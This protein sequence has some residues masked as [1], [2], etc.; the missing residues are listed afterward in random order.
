MMLLNKNDFVFLVLS[1]LTLAS[2]PLHADIT[3]N[4]IA[5]Y[6]FE[7]DFTDSKGSADG[8]PIG[9]VSF[10]AGKV[11]QQAA[12][13]N[14]VDGWIDIG[15]LPHGDLS[16]YTFSA[17]V[18]V[19][20]SLDNKAMMSNYP[21][22]SNIHNIINFTIVRDNHTV[23]PSNTWGVHRDADPFN[24]GNYEAG[25]SV[26]STST[27][28]DQFTHI[29]IVR[30]VAASEM[31]IYING[32]LD[33]VGVLTPLTQLPMTRNTDWK[34]GRINENYG[35]YFY[36]ALDDVRLY[37]RAL[38]DD[39]IIQ[40]SNQGNKIFS[41]GFETGDTS[42][43]D[44][45]SAQI[46]KMSATNVT[47]YQG[48]YSARSTADYQIL[49]KQF[50]AINSGIAIV[51]AYVMMTQ[52][53]ANSYLAVVI[54][55]DLYGGS[56][57]HIGLAFGRPE[58][59]FVSWFRDDNWNED[60]INHPQTAQ[61]G[62]WYKVTLKH[63]FNTG[64]SSVY[65]NDDFIHQKTT[66]I[67]SLSAIWIGDGTQ[68]SGGDVISDNYF[69]D[70]ITV[71]HSSSIDTV[72]ST[73][74]IIPSTNPTPIDATNSSTEGTNSCNPTTTITG[75]PGPIVA[76]S[77]NYTHTH[78]DFAIPGLGPRL[79]ITRYYNSQDLYDGPFS[80][81]WNIDYTAQLLL[82]EDDQGAQTATVRLGNGVRR[83]FTE[84]VDGSWIPPE[85]QDDTLLTQGTG[86]SAVYVFNGDCGT[87][88]VPKPR[89]SYSFNADG[90]LQI[91]TD[92]NGNTLT[93]GYDGSGRISAV[94]NP[95][96][97]SLSFAYGT[98]GRVSTVTDHD[99]RTWTYGYDPLTDDLISVEDPLGNT[100]QYAYDDAHNLISL[101]D[102]KGQVQQ[103]MT[104]LTDDKVAYFSDQ[105]GAYNV[106][107][108]SRLLR[109][110][111]TNPEGGL[112][113]FNYDN[114]GNITNKTNALGHQSALTWDANVDLTG[115][116]NGRNVETSYSY[117]AQHNVTQVIRDAGN[118]NLTS[119][120]SYDPVTGQVA[121][122]INPR[123]I[124]TQMLYDVN[125]NLDTV[126]RDALGSPVV[127]DTQYN[128]Q[129]Q[130]TQSTDADGI[131][132]AY[133]YDADGYMTRVYNPNVLP[134]DPQIET[135]YTYDARGNRLTQTDANGNTTTY[136]YDDLDRV[137][138]VTDALTN[139]T[140]FVY[141][142]NGN[143]TQITDARNN[144]TQLAYDSYDRLISRT[145]A[146]GTALQR[147]T[148]YT[149]DSRGNLL[150]VTDPLLHTT[151]YTYDLIS[152][153]TQACDHLNQCWSF[154]YDEAGNL[155]SKTDPNNHS[156][157]YGYD[158]IDRLAS[159]NDAATGV[160]QY[161]YDANS[162]LTQVTD[163]NIHT[164]AQ[165]TYDNLDRLTDTQDAL[166]FNTQSSYSGAG[167]I[168]TITDANS[169]LITNGYDGITGRLSQT[170][171]SAGGTDSYT[172]DPVGN[173]LSV[174]DSATGITLGYTYDALNRIATETQQGKTLTYTYDENGNRTGLNVTGIGS[175]SYTYD[176]L[177]RLISIQNPDL[178]TTAFEYNAA[179]LRT[180]VTY[181]NGSTTEYTYDAVNRLTQILHKKAD[182]TVISG[183][184][185]TYD[186]MN[187]RL[188]E[189]DANSNTL[190]TYVYDERYQL[191]SATYADTNETISFTY[192]AV[193]NRLT[194]TDGSGTTSYTYNDANQ[195]TDQN[196]PDGSL[197]TY[198]YLPN[199]TPFT[200]IQ[201]NP[202][203][204]TFTTTYTYDSKDRL[205]QL[206]GSD[207]SQ[208][209]FEYDPAGRRIST[210]VGATL[211]KHLYDGQNPLAELDDL[212]AIQ[213]T[214]TPALTLDVLASRKTGSTTEYYLR[215]GLNSVRTIV[216]GTE[217]ETASYLYQPYGKIRTKTG[218]SD[219]AFTFTGRRIV[220]NT[221][222]MFYRS[223]YYD[224]ATGRF[225][226]KD[227]YKGKLNDPL[228]MHRYIYVQNNPVNYVDPLGF[229]WV[230]P[231]CFIIPG[232]KYCSSG[233][234]DTDAIAEV[235]YQGDGIGNS[236]STF[237]M[238]EFEYGETIS[239]DQTDS[240]ISIGANVD[241]GVT[242]LG[243]IDDE[244]LED[245]NE[246]VS[247][248]ISGNYKIG[249]ELSFY[250]NKQESFLE[251][252]KVWDSVAG[253]NAGISGGIGGE[254]QVI[255]MTV[256]NKN[257]CE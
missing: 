88:C 157:G 124:S 140:S 2:F 64:V 22:G 173:L 33:T 198:H 225:L 221:D 190:V 233:G 19:R 119:S 206:N 147:S 126:T 73:D 244:A 235:S 102:A 105:G 27:I 152:Q 248:D 14:G 4:L 32:N 222:L 108:N 31:R 132:T 35:R 183:H 53:E 123:S 61:I 98:N 216:D 151:T 71:Y 254:F 241:A 1:V 79:G 208:Q 142:A 38:S 201:T 138:S 72:V 50:A 36:G 197:T 176:A 82:S 67:N 237:T 255:E 230:S 212:N 251:Y 87:G 213:T 45:Y 165:N 149:Y 220:D 44:Q 80:H 189:T 207:G 78:T 174:T 57:G 166:T 76:S 202:D 96:S 3:S 11:G 125:G 81:G 203:T 158:A 148:S 128:T 163:A 83:R 250:F 99:T 226:K 146:V 169:Q 89:R 253:F 160:S 84:N 180:K 69:I 234:F 5:H 40:L 239:L 54:E 10:V 97:R 224:T 134:A 86:P 246:L 218:T 188:S 121:E 13:F 178:E 104:Y 238:T 16:S 23:Y 122:S 74:V 58:A 232:D 214:Y 205:I 139:T 75:S 65:L 194:K 100:I 170:Q 24:G 135:S 215:D 171:Y 12:F 249:G 34:I 63:D 115:K 93:L 187:N 252:F 26:F 30:D 159:V 227:S 204:S 95:N 144:V 153:L 150:S 56:D 181:G 199:G 210:T 185:Y 247:I 164:A 110:T 200:R 90:F 179:D 129:G 60:R 137:T 116:T 256:N 130:L 109:T 55:G 127:T 18:D 48:T 77:G 133:E 219:S 39:D 21:V 143:L 182:G 172:Y 217:T 231:L 101:S 70:N 154:N 243:W 117:D 51:D 20:H 29:A 112:F 242:M 111:K 47:S 42:N 229:R 46:Q 245:G 211:T 131:A 155:I 52:R 240:Y 236:T 25:D 196:N 41:D 141:D 15:T 136:V 113:T 62:T 120:F 192:D 107:Y 37:S 228:S 257:N 193:G 162:N 195:L 17:W 145:E 9:G 161:T 209:V 103:S 8:S 7:G 43:W 49:T 118:F 167:R 186:A 66:N 184:G 6:E 168:Q 223:R 59:D 91:I 156:T 175:Y 68:T 177:N 106:N 114:N 94:T 28:Y 191:T 85:G 92:K